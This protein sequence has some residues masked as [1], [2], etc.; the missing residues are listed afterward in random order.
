MIFWLRD[1]R[2]A[3][4]RIVCDGGG[5]YGFGNLRRSIALAE[6]LR[7]SGYRVSVDAVSEGA[8]QLL[9]AF[10]NDDGPGDVW[11]LDLPYEGDKWVRKGQASKRPVAALDFIGTGA[12]DL[13]ISIFD[14][15]LAPAAAKHLVGLQY[16][17]IRP[18]IIAL[19]PAAEGEGVVVMIGGG[20]KDGLGE[21]VAE[22]IQTDTDG[23]T[24]IEG[25]L[26]EK[27]RE[28]APAIKRLNSP[29]ELARL[30]A[31]CAWAVTSGGGTMLEMMCLAK[32]VHVVPRTPFEVSLAQSIL[33]QG[34]LLGVGIENIGRPSPERRRSV[35]ATARRLVDGKGTVRIATALQ[36]LL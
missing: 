19:A 26:A 3:H 36:A 33:G 24:L 12:P 31:G 13:N 30:M 25:P 14:H 6:S 23:I 35:A 10:Q 29:P 17:I 27:S 1:K 34:A 15:G 2:M 7:R 22:M 21:R 8:R 20:D 16:A 5:S 18:D 32:A 28:L 4:V 9:P 11:L